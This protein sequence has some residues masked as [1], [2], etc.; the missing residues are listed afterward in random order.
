MPNFN[1]I[2][3]KDNENLNNQSNL[4]FLSNNVKGLQSTKK[5]LKL[6]NFLKNKIG[7]KVILFLKETYFSVETEKWIDDFKD[8]IYY[9]H[10][11]TNSCGVLIGIYGNLNICVKN[12]VHDN[13]GRVLILEATI[14]GSDYLLINFYNA[15]TE[16]E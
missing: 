3:F 12:N 11:K 9:S 16:R 2:V 8:K 15:N 10:G 5:R 13:G 4:N 6:F 7:P 1:E 14:N